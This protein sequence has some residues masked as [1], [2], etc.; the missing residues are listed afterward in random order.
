[1]VGSTISFAVTSRGRGGA[2]TVVPS[3]ITLKVRRTLVLALQRH[4]RK[5]GTTQID[6]SAILTIFRTADDTLQMGPES[7]PRSTEIPSYSAGLGGSLRAN[8]LPSTVISPVTVSAPKVGF[9]D[10]VGPIIAEKG[11]RLT[12]DE[13]SFLRFLYVEL[14]DSLVIFE[15]K[16]FTFEHGQRPT[17]GIQHEA[18]TRVA[19][20][21]QGGSS[22]IDAGNYQSI[23]DVVGRYLAQK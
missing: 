2:A 21:I 3:E 5:A 11:L 15:K 20:L 9:E 14:P 22:A 16:N 1:M 4:F 18:R 8:R 12:T 10:F 23:V 17:A 7:L 6:P 13:T 19:W